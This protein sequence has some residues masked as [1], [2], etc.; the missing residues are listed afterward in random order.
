M[1]ILIATDTGST[2][3]KTA[4]GSIEPFNSSSDG[5]TNPSDPTK[6]PQKYGLINL[7]AFTISDSVGKN[8]DTSDTI[9]GTFSR[10]SLGSK[11]AIPII[12][13]AKFEKKKIA[14][15]QLPTGIGG[16]RVGS[17]QFESVSYL[18]AWAYSRTI[19]MLFYVPSED[20]N[21]NLNY[22]QVKDF[23]NSNLRTLY[24]TFWDKNL[25]NENLGWNDDSYGS[26]KFPIEMSFGYQ[27]CAIPMIIE[28]CTTKDTAGGTHVEVTVTGFLVVNED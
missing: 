24:D 5:I 17:E 10:I 27:A 18:K 15:A 16:E 8:V 14:L 6:Y 2:A 19:I 28:N 4:S 25:G 21:N 7:K 22:G 23:Y 13:T 12:L 9:A 26:L 1:G 11:K 3:L 20:N